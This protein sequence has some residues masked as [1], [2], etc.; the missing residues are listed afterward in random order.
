MGNYVR[1]NIPKAGRELREGRTRISRPSG[2]GG[3]CL[4]GCRPAM[5]KREPIVFVVYAGSDFADAV[6]SDVEAFLLCFFE[7][8]SVRRGHSRRLTFAGDAVLT[9]LM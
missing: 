1:E 4:A 3:R 9:L 5:Q 6:G 2:R 8:G 7:S